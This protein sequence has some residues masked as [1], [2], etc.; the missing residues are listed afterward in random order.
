MT[1][2]MHLRA[3]VIA[4]RMKDLEHADARLAEARALALARTTGELP[5]FG[6][7]WAPT[8]VGVH[9]VAIHQQ[10]DAARG[11][12][13]VRGVGER[14]EEN[15]RQLGW[16]LYVMYEVGKKDPTML[17]AKATTCAATCGVSRVR[18]NRRRSAGSRCRPVRS[19]RCP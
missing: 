17:S 11:D 19:A 9:P 16:V 2:V 18:A 4:G 14:E 10:I 5:D 15:L 8:N 3:T 7:T 6:V 1:G 13:E 12:H